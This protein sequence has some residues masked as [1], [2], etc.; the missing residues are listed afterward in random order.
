[1]SW[2]FRQRIL[3]SESVLSG[4]KVVSTSREN[5]KNKVNVVIGT[6]TVVLKY[7]SFLALIFR[8]C[9][10]AMY[11]HDFGCDSDLQVKTVNVGYQLLKSLS[12]LLKLLISEASPS[13]WMWTSTSASATT[14]T[15]MR[16]S[17]GVTSSKLSLMSSSWGSLLNIWC[18][19]EICG[20]WYWQPEINGT[21]LESTMS[22]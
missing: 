12:R 15:A 22:S 10:E 18:K 14:R 1:M 16:W 8:G 21:R 17:P 9:A 2:V 6:V 5:I 7:F 11:E 4:S 13:R 20:L 3:L 19:Q